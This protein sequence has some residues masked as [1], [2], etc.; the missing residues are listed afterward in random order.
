M[1]LATAWQAHPGH[2]VQTV[3][4]IGEVT[5]HNEYFGTVGESLLYWSAGLPV[6]KLDGFAFIHEQ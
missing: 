2:G 6:L 5:R 1:N 3:A 4:R